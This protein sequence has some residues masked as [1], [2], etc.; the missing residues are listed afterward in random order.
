MLRRND[1]G[2]IKRGEGGSKKVKRDEG[3]GRWN[4]EG[5][6]LTYC[7]VEINYHYHVTSLICTYVYLKHFYLNIYQAHI[8]VTS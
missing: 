1:R 5:W 4:F 6:C 2:Q 7:K 8:H 3:K